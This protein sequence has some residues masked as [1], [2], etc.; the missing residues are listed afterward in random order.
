MVARLPER[1]CAGSCSVIAV[2]IA[3]LL[4]AYR[5]VMTM[6]AEYSA[7]SVR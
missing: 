3:P 1:R 6:L 2:K 4:S 7:V 5:I